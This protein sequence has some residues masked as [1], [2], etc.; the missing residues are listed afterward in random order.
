MKRKGDINKELVRCGK[1]LHEGGFAIGSGGNLSVR[2]GSYI[3]I[4][5]QGADLSKAKITDYLRISMKEAEKS[6]AGISSE[7]PLHLAS[8]AARPEAGAVIHVHSPVMVAVAEKTRLL[9][10]NSYEFDCVMGG[11]IP[12][13]PFIKPGTRALAEA[14]ASKVKSG[15]NAV[16]MARHGAVCVGHNIEETYVRV[17]A[18]ERA[19]LTF[20]Y[21][22]A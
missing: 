1:L 6:P 19:A 3:V 15:A 4:K 7:T 9:K 8:Y 12:V 17:L 22:S 14:V 18:L 11:D 10:S 20:L 13:V 2:D 5:R 16:L 21:L